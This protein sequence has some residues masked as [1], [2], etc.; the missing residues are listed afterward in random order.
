MMAEIPAAD[1][2]AH[3]RVTQRRLLARALKLRCPNCGRPGIFRSAFRLYRRCPDCG[4]KFERSDGFFLG[5]M[6]V[7]Y[8]VTVFVALP[9][10]VLLAYAGWLT[11]LQAVVA[12]VIIAVLVPI[13]IYRLAW[14]LWLGIYYFFLPHELPAN[15]TEM[16]PVNEDE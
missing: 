13:L 12:A 7:N 9:P 5:A 14:S 15:E 8:A 11:T 6:T 3:E 16:I 4:L 10:L 2:P 1:H